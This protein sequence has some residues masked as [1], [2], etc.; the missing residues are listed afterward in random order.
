MATLTTTTSVT[1]NT[2]NSNVLDSKRIGKLAGQGLFN[3]TIAATGSAT[4][5]EHEVFVGN[6]NPVE[7][8]S[9]SLQ[10]RIPIVRDD[11]VA[12]FQARGGEEIQVA[13]HNTTGAALSYFLTV[14]RERA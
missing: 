12:A 11:V 9:V 1:A 6:D 10:N 13:V 3:V 8:S 7:R 2:T 14:I 5:L 4:G